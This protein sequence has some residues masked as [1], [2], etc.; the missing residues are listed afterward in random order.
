MLCNENSRR[1]GSGVLKSFYQHTFSAAQT[2]RRTD[3]RI[4]QWLVESRCPIPGKEALWSPVFMQKQNEAAPICVIGAV[5][6][7]AR[8][9]FSCEKCC[10]IGFFEKLRLF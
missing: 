8:S 2:G 6:L 9:I 5:F 1:S 4:L 7:F 3:Q 10:E